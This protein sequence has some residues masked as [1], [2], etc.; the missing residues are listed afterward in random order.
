MFIFACVVI[1]LHHGI[2]N[3]LPQWRLGAH[4]R[5]MTVQLYGVWFHCSKG[6]S[7]VWRENRP[8]ELDTLPKHPAFSFTGQQSTH[9]SLSQSGDFWPL[10]PPTMGSCQSPVII[11]PG[12]SCS[13]KKRGPR[14]GFLADL[15]NSKSSRPAGGFQPWMLIRAPA[16]HR[17]LA[18]PVPYPQ[19]GFFD[20]SVV[21]PRHWCF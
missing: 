10:L 21:W 6:F 18:T 9:L 1:Y 16:G 11:V 17:N 5:L 20:W 2:H 15:Q 19:R 4:I 8:G 13:F 3:S 7:E 12:T 14:N